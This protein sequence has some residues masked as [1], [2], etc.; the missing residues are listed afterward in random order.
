MSITNIDYCGIS[1]AEK[2]KKNH[3]RLA[4]SVYFLWPGAFYLTFTEKFF[5]ILDVAEGVMPQPKM[6]SMQYTDFHTFI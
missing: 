3:P 1:F 4:H 5:C 6:H 2:K